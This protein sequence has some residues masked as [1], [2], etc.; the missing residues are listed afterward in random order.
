MFIGDMV[1]EEV[2]KVVPKLRQSL[3][4]R[5]R[6]ML[7]SSVKREINDTVG[8]DAC[9]STSAGT[10]HGMPLP[11]THAQLEQK[12]LDMELNMSLHWNI[13]KSL[14]NILKYLP[15]CHMK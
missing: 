14:V 10:R 13:R 6:F 5:L 12:L 4:V 3:Q 7:Q 15:S 8:G 9:T 2:Q 11:L 1:R